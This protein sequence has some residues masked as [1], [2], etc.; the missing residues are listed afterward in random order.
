MIRKYIKSSLSTA[1]NRTADNTVKGILNAIIANAIINWQTPTG[2]TIGTTIKSVIAYE[3]NIYMSQLS[4]IQRIERKKKILK[5]DEQFISKTETLKTVKSKIAITDKVRITGTVTVTNV[6]PPQ[7]QI[8]DGSI[9]SFNTIHEIF[10]NDKFKYSYSKTTGLYVVYTYNRAKINP[11]PGLVLD[12]TYLSEQYDNVFFTQMPNT[13]TTTSVKTKITDA[14]NVYTD[15][16][17]ALVYRFNTNTGCYIQDKKYY[18]YSKTI[19][20][21]PPKPVFS[22]TKEIDLTTYMPIN[23]GETLTIGKYLLHGN[24]LCI[25]FFTDIGYEANGS[26]IDEDLARMYNI[27]TGTAKIKGEIILINRLTWDIK[28]ISKTMQTSDG[29]IRYNG[30][31]DIIVDK[32]TGKLIIAEML[33]DSVETSLTYDTAKIFVAAADSPK[34]PKEDIT[35]TTYA[36]WYA[37]LNTMQSNPPRYHVIKDGT[38]TWN[39]SYPKLNISLYDVKINPSTK[40]MILDLDS[41]VYEDDK[42]IT[43]RYS[44]DCFGGYINCMLYQDTF[45]P[46]YTI[47]IGRNYTAWLQ[48]PFISDD[49]ILKPKHR[50]EIWRADDTK[51]L[52]AVLPGEIAGF[53]G[54]EFAA[55]VPKTEVTNTHLYVIADIP[56]DFGAARTF[57]KDDTPGSAAA[58]IS[59][60]FTS[61]HTTLMALADY[62]SNDS[63]EYIKN[64][65]CSCIFTGGI[66]NTHYPRSIAYNTYNLW[67]TAI[68]TYNDRFIVIQ[69]TNKKLKV[70]FGG[71]LPLQ[72]SE[73]TLG[74]GTSEIFQSHLMNSLSEDALT[75]VFIGGN[76]D[77]SLGL[78]KLELGGYNFT[79]KYISNNPPDSRYPIAQFVSQFTT[80][81]NRVSLLKLDINSYYISQ[82]IYI[83]QF[84]TFL[85]NAGGSLWWGLD[86]QAYKYI[87][88]QDNTTSLIGWVADMPLDII[89]QKWADESVTLRLIKERYGAAV[90]NLQYY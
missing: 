29:Q 11:L 50:T 23:T 19:E 64:N 58:A 86:R 75:G 39:F 74:D 15:L 7:G 81:T 28:K 65:S 89:Y 43:T 45:D 82:S 24:I 46:N 90:N 79:T 30:F 67:N 38:K 6:S 83:N 53:F 57:M 14:D 2:A 59:G 10:I 76:I 34:T 73:Y 17:L 3:V 47:Y 4:E 25:L 48:V 36:S 18:E 77:E 21:G 78:Y 60:A 5:G 70:V 49:F 40:E 44:Y 1:N 9:I 20:G 88:T 27:H 33:E 62:V 12:D 85:Y 69:D 80:T 41:I 56:G 16:T 22:I 71:V 55:I 51:Y 35:K 54:T 66:N 61:T 68:N 84:D 31:I 87:E 63:I 32:K 52:N 26:D 37:I 13:N 42:L 72:V 8:E